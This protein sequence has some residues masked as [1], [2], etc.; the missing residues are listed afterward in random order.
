MSILWPGN[1]GPLTPCPKW[2]LGV[3]VQR[4]VGELKSIWLETLIFPNQGALES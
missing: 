4:A 1:R 2:S 3:V